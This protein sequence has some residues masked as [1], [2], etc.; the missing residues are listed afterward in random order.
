LRIASSP[1]KT[2]VYSEE[3]ASMTELK[4]GEQRGAGGTAGVGPPSGGEEDEQGRVPSSAPR[5]PST[6]GTDRDLDRSGT[7]ANQG[8][9]HPR[10]ERGRND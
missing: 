3:E 1:Y 5:E 4:K 2:G 10:E 8:H 6:A 7:S 9:G